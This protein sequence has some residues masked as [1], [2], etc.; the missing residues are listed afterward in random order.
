MKLNKNENINGFIVNFNNVNTM[1]Q[2]TMH[3]IIGKLKTKGFIKLVI[4]EY[5]KYFL[6]LDYDIIKE[7]KYKLNDNNIFFNLKNNK[8]INNLNKI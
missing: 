8:Y 6:I 2:T 1:I 5:I 3:F 4:G 7:G